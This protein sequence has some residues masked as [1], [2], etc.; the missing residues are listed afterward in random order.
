MQS[1]SRE[2]ELKG[3]IKVRALEL[4]FESESKTS[5]SRRQSRES[6]SNSDFRIYAYECGRFHLQRP[7]TVC[8]A[9]DVPDLWRAKTQHSSA[10]TYLLT[11]LKNQSPEI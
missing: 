6:E 4:E 3:V 5:Q 7:I 1:R 8:G 2:F 9:G 10:L 11:I